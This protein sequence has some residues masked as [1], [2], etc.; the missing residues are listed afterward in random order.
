MNTLHVDLG[1]RSYPIFIGSDLLDNSELSMQ[2]CSSRRRVLITDSNVAQHYLSRVTKSFEVAKLDQ[3][4]L[5]P[6]E[7]NK[8]IATL[9]LIFD[10]LLD[11]QCD[12]KTIILALGG[13]VTGDMSGFAAACFQ[14]GID[15]IQL[16]TTILSQVDSSVGG[17]TGVN[18]PA[19]KNMIGAFHQPIAV[20]IDTKTLLTLP[21]R[22]ITAGIAEI[23]KYGLIRDLDFLDWLEANLDGLRNLHPAVL[24]EAIA[25][26][27]T[28]KASVVSADEKE[29]G[30]R[31]ILNLGHT[32]GHAVETIAGYGNW[33]H[34][35]AVG[36]GM[37]MAAALSVL[38][39]TLSPADERRINQLLDR[40]N[41]PAT[42]PNNATDE[43]L[44]RLM[45]ADKKAEAGNLTMIT[46]NGLGNAVVN[47]TVTDQQIIQ[48]VQQF[49]SR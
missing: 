38:L 8:S 42:L 49:H 17:K 18:H 10:F 27:C 39:G 46:L 30:M 11:R 34:G 14:R 7:S 37:R 25:K 20:I 28:S 16:P 5:E 13:G 12:R 41:L 33:L 29:Q 24:T 15:F 40:A 6:G 31:A 4:I 47:K 26:S 1:N 32:F 44:L 21:E 3:L 19:G 36:L 35:E 22:E 23:I 2:T 9:E 48:V 45:H 43:Q